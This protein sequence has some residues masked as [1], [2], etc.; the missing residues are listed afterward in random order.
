M[1]DKVVNTS[2]T[3]GQR[4][5]EGVKEGIIGAA[6]GAAAGAVT[7]GVLNSLDGLDPTSETMNNIAAQMGGDKVEAG[8]T[9]I[10]SALSDTSKTIAGEGDVQSKLIAIVNEFSQAVEPA[11]SAA[12]G[13]RENVQILEGVKEAYLNPTTLAAAGAA[14]GGTFKAGEG[15][16]SS[17]PDRRQ[18]IENTIQQQQIM[19]V[20][21]LAGMA[22]AASASAN[23]G[24]KV[25][26]E[27]TAKLLKE[28]GQQAMVPPASH[29]ER[30]QQQRLD[31]TPTLGA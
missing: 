18:D 30:V 27:H 3:I 10:K 21:Q 9:A 28:R 13:V 1:A 25:V 7:G 14:A 5:V 20:G 24:L 22:L 29:V 16:L 2:P 19:S 4:V 26:G 11:Q 23:E 17:Q 31:P 15:L 12:Q 8:T 6:L